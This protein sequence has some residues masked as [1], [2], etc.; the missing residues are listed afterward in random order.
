MI[1]IDCP[2]CAGAASLVVAGATDLDEAVECA[3]CGVRVEFAA[4][5]PAWELALAA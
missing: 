4:D 1:Q 5:A 3:G 2:W